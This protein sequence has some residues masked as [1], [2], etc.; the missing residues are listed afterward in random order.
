MKTIAITSYLTFVGALIL[1]SCAQEEMPV[2]V[3]NQSDRRIV[4]NTSFPELTT[5]ASEIAADLPH[6][7]ITAFDETDS[8]LVEEG[9]LKEYI[10]SLQIVKNAGSGNFLSDQCV[11]PDPGKESDKLHFFAFYPTLNVGATLVNATAVDESTGSKTVGYQVKDFRVAAD[12]AD[13]VDF[14]TAYATGSME[15]NLFNGISLKFRHQLSRI[16]VKAKGSHKSCNI[17][18]AGVRIGNFAMNGSFEFPTSEDAD[19]VWK[20]TSPGTAEYI[21][22]RGDAIVTT[23][24][25]EVSI[26]GNKTDN[27]AM[28]IPSTYSAW[29]YLSDKDN[30]GKGMYISVLLRI[31]DK[32]NDNKQEYPYYD[33]KQGL[34]APNVPVVYLAVKTSGE[35]ST[36]LYKKDGAY[37]TDENCTVAYPLY[38]NEEVREF[39][40]AAVPVKGEWKPGHTYTYTLDYSS[41][42]GIHDPDVVGD[43]AP[44]AGDPIIRDMLGISVTVTE[45]NNGGV[46]SATVPGS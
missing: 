22:R 42:V 21:F 35:V 17:Q 41:G 38:V 25:T 45:W 46:S 26:M 24:N 18:I 31:L 23:D 14:V 43:V 1:S 16:E 40:W 9:K 15:D 29:D 37:F 44:K 33:T 12:I 6:F 3:P 11:W 34:N 10:D 27:Y 5:R 32:Y 39:G 7:Y 19:G 8:K 4:F 30:T 20:A 13:Q 28:L 36:R 2:D